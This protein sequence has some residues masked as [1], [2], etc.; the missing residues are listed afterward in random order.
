MCA[1]AHVISQAE[2]DHVEW[3]THM[4]LGNAQQGE[5]A[6]MREQG[7]PLYTYTVDQYAE[8]VS[9]AKAKARVPEHTL[10]VEPEPE[11][12]VD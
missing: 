5:V 11:L 9:L 6:W 3:S 4:G 1:V 2:N 8:L 12:S 10:S 7:I